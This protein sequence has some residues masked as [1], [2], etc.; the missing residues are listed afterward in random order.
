MLACSVTVRVGDWA[1][2]TCGVRAEAR[3]MAAHRSTR[4]LEPVIEPDRQP[5]SYAGTDR[6]GCVDAEDTPIEA[7]P[8]IHD[9]GVQRPQPT[10]RAQLTP[11]GDRAPLAPR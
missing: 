8:H 5:K 3:A 1:A 4:T 2:P 10:H 7:Q 9:P 11:L 6:P